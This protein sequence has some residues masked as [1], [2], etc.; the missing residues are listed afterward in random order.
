MA[1]KEFKQ[2][3]GKNG[4]VVPDLMNWA[5]SVLNQE[6]KKEFDEAMARRQAH[7]DKHVAAGNIV[8]IDEGGNYI[9]K[10]KVVVEEFKDDVWLFYL[11]KYIKDNDLLYINRWDP[12]YI[13]PGA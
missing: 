6:S 8:M 2:V 9:W 3:F 13:I 1:V 5:N 4:G 11:T 7:K 10:N 12:D